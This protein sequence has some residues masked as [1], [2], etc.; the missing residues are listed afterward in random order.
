[1]AMNK[2]EPR[3]FFMFWPFYARKWSDNGNLRA[4][5]ILP[6]FGIPM[7]SWG[8]DKKAGNFNLKLFWFFYQYGYSKNPLMKK[9]VIFPF[10]IHYRFGS[11]DGSYYRDSKIVLLYAKMQTRSTIVDS[12]YHI[13][14]PFYWNAKRHYKQEDVKEKYIKIWP[15]FHY[16]KDTAGNRHFRTL[17]LWPFRSEKVDRYWG[18]IWTL[19]EYGRM[20]NGD[21]YHSVLLRLFSTYKSENRRRIFLAGFDTM[22]S[23]D[24]FSIQFLGG[25]F[26]YYRKKFSDEEVSLD[27]VAEEDRKKK[28]KRRIKLFWYTFGKKDR[29]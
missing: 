7:F 24:E 13:F 10:W 18:P 11:E 8:R 28:I 9:H 6:L 12:D 22:K 25:L 3:K 15:L 16:R 14:F 1:V 5:A 17:D 23:K 21:R 27:G 29:H 20:D 4:H 26:G 19:Y 2:K